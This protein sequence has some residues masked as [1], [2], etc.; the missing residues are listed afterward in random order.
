MSSAVYIIE[1]SSYNNNVKY[2][3]S[4]FVNRSQ[5]TLTLATMK[6]TLTLLAH[7]SLALALP[8]LFPSSGPDI[9]QLD[10]N[11]I[12][13]LGASTVNSVGAFTGSQLDDMNTIGETLGGR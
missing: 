6:F 8:A 12:S 2:N 4:F 7:I 13:K 9:D 3:I 1:L 11:E 10:I 5:F